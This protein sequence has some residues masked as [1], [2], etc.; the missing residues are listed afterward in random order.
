[1]PDVIK[2]LL[3]QLLQRV[4]GPAHRAA[5][6]ACALVR[7]TTESLLAE[8]MALPDAHDLF[9]WLRSLSFIQTRLGG[10]FSHDIARKVLTTD[11]RWRNPDWYS[12]LHRRAR[13][14]YTQR[15]QQTQGAEQQ[16]ALF[17][18]VYLHRD[19]PAVRPFFEWQVSGRTLPD[20]L[21]AAD[22]EALGAMVARHEGAESAQLARYWLD[23]QQHGAPPLRARCSR[24][25]PSS[26]RDRPRRTSTTGP[27]TTPTCSRRRHK[28]R[29]PSCS[30]CLSARIAAI[31][32]PA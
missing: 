8:L 25:Q 18:L 26:C 21:R 1:M 3:E 6:E 4:P 5:L 10:L 24:P 9:E 32:R 13:V 29:P 11:L 7:V 28:N 15:L 30:T 2:A 12:E 27:F 20:R 23:H 14:H 16:L 22:I 17:D 31:S 19:N